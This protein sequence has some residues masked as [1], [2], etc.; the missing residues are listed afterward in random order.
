YQKA[1]YWVYL[2]IFYGAALLLLAGFVVIGIIGWLLLRRLVTGVAA[3]QLLTKWLAANA[4]GKGIRALR[5]ARPNQAAV[6]VFMIVVMA[7]AIVITDLFGND[8]EKTSLVRAISKLGAVS[9]VVLFLLLSAVPTGIIGWL[10]LRRLGS[11]YRARWISDQSI[12]IDA[13]WLM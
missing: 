1:F 13:V 9:N 12:M 6:V 11:L 8:E 5:F 10:L 4:T 7:G 3:G 2:G